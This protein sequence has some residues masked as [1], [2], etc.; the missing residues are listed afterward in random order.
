M[1]YDS[2][3]V[4]DMHCHVGLLGDK[5][6]QWGKFSDWYCEQLVFKTFLL[7][8]GLKENEVSDIKL[9]EK[10]EEEITNSTLNHI[11]C[12]AL[13]PVYDDQGNRREDLSHM[14]VD[15][16][17]ILDLRDRIGDKVMLGASVHPFD[18]NFEHRVKKY[19]D[20]GAAVGSTV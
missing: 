4:I 1:P 13:D 16:D 9:R 12:L 10:T 15:N 7:F 20:K 8:S 5:F 17:Y 14:W 19:V 2:K 3:K 18:K 11:I 6:P